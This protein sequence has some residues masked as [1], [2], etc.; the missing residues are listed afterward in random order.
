MVKKDK[1]PKYINIL[2]AFW[3][4]LLI[5]LYLLTISTSTSTKDRYYDIMESSSQKAKLAFQKIKEKKQE[6]GLT[7]SSEDKYQSGM[8]GPLHSK[9]QTTE[10]E[11]AAKRTS[12][13]PNF[14]AVYI[15]MFKEANLKS[16]DEIAIV[17]SGSF[18]ALNISATIAAQEYGLK[19]VSM[20]GIGAS[21]YGATD[22]NFT[23]FDMAN[24]LYEIGIYENKLDYVSFGGAYDTGAEF[25]D[26]LINDMMLRIN[27]SGVS[28]ISEA[29][30]QKNVQLRMNY[31]QTKCPNLKLFL[32]VG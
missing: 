18:P 32:N 16:G 5:V 22:T 7:L 9:I 1:S 10:G 17:T 15:Q 29:D 25:A 20:T 13:N 14:A 27:A 24:Y 2:L 4:V 11:P 28:L 30:F 31:I 19:F 8:L 26:D 12:T 3:A 6:I 21:S 23:Y